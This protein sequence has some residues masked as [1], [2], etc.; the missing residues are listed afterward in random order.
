MDSKKK[1]EPKALAIPW[2]F[3]AFEVVPS[4]FVFS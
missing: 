1:K 2:S 3:E 4:R